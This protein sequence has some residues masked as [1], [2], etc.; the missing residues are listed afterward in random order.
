MV[1]A[2]RKYTEDQYKEAI[3]ML[4]QGQTI[5]AIAASVGISS[6]QV[7]SIRNRALRE[8]ISGIPEPRPRQSRRA[9]GI[10]AVRPATQQ[11]SI[12][13]L[14]ANFMPEEEEEEES[15]QALALQLREELANL[16]RERIATSRRLEALQRAE[17]WWLLRI[18]RVEQG[19]EDPGSVPESDWEPGAEE[20]EA[21]PPARKKAGRKARA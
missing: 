17:A 3:A 8:G 14:I 16:Q 10:S 19:E 21:A 13:R 20:E 5:A 11:T 6:A 4:R 7:Q 1:G 9:A 12:D 2:P 15:S 18:T